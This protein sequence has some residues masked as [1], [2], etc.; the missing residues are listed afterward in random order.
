MRMKPLYLVRVSLGFVVLVTILIMRTLWM[1]G[2]RP[3]ETLQTAVPYSFAAVILVVYAVMIRYT[4][5]QLGNYN[6]EHDALEPLRRALP[7]IPSLTEAEHILDQQDI[8]GQN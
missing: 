5:A 4:Q 2:L 3:L 8:T 7:P 6:R 1:S